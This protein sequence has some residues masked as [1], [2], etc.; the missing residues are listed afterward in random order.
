MEQL[1]DTVGGDD[2]KEFGT[3]AKIIR[4]L[5]GSISIISKDKFMGDKPLVEINLGNVPISENSEERRKSDI[6]K[7]PLI[8][9]IR[10]GN[11][12]FE[13]DEDDNI[14]VFSEKQFLLQLKEF[15]LTFE[16]FDL[17]SENIDIKSD[18]YN[19][20]SAEEINEKTQNYKL[21]TETAKIN[22]QSEVVI[23]APVIKIGELFQEGEEFEGMKIG[24][25]YETVMTVARFRKWWNGELKP[26]FEY[27]KTYIDTIYNNHTHTGVTTGEG[28]SLTPVQKGSGNKMDT[29][30]TASKVTGAQT[31]KTI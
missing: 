26:V 30:L 29:G 23:S 6:T 24:E 8:F 16:N 18:K 22:A 11:V 5:N 10:A 20:D 13:I 31:L 28:T 7:K 1:G 21:E 15:L 27:L 25:D 4:R 12:K 2:Y 19:L 14:I 17:L 9:N 3:Q